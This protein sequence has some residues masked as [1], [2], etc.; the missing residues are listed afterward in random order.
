MGLSARPQVQRGSRVFG[1]AIVRKADLSLVIAETNHAIESPLWHGEVYALKAYY[2]LPAAERPP[3]TEC[4]FIATHE[5]CAMCLSAITWAGLDN[6]AYLFTYQ[7]S[8][9][10]FGMPVDLEM[11]KEVFTLERGAYRRCAGFQLLNPSCLVLDRA[12]ARGFATARAC[13]KRRKGPDLSSW[14][15]SSCA[16]RQKA[17][18]LAT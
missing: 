11:M 13:R 1:G 8:M 16:P 14:L 10:S 4:F 12:V 3:L 6:F 9:D 5:P 18:R 2:D 17:R 7:D 15:S